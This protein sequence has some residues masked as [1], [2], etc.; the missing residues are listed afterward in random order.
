MSTTLTTIGSR[1][2]LEVCYRMRAV[3]MLVIAGMS[4]LLVATIVTR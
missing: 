3:E 2:V 1:R 4:L